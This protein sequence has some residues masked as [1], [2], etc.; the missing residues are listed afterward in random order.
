MTRA[1]IDTICAICDRAHKELGISKDERISLI[2]DLESLPELDYEQLLIMPSSDFG[3]DIHG[4]RRYMDRSTWPG[5]LTSCFWPR[6][7]SL[8]GGAQ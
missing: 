2:M 5:K 4:I 8:K 3:H 7:G 6:C 1:D